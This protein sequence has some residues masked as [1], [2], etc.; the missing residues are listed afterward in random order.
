MSEKIRVWDLPTR[1]FHWAL[2]LCVSGLFTTAWFGSSDLLWHFRFGYATLS[3][4]LFRLVW[5]LVGGHWSRFGSFLFAPA[6]LKRYLR[7][8]VQ[9]ELY[10]GHSPTA[11]LSV[12]A[13]L[14]I[15]LLQIATG[16]FSDDEV[17][18]QGPLTAWV[19]NAWVEGLTF[20]HADIGQYLVLAL[21]GLHVAAVAYY[22]LFKKQNLVRSM[23]TGDKS[24]LPSPVVNSRDDSWK[25]L[26][27]LAIYL[28][29]LGLVLWL[30]K[31]A[32]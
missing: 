22:L 9:P 1:L 27:A 11:A 21:V 31:L 18:A 26:L 25:R 29:C 17:S 14:G 10:L 2:V 19:P 3:L 23:F 6:T 7:G 4:L 32:G 20:Y 5:G 24:A 13:M 16:L 28:V 30:L 8:E 15:L 12:F